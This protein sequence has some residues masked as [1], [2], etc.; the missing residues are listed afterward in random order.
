MSISRG[1]SG[2]SLGRIWE[3]I[4]Y[5]AHV[6]LLSLLFTRTHLVPPQK[7]QEDFDPQ[8]QIVLNSFMLET[9]TPIPPQQQVYSISLFNK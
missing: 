9:E 3:G 7:T 4:D 2:A 6:Y 1:Q 5:Q 8:S